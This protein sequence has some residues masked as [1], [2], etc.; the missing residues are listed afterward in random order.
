[1]RFALRLAR[2]L[3]RTLHELA[4]TMTAE[5]FALHYMDSCIEP[6]GDARLAHEMAA[7]RSATLKGPVQNAPCIADCLLQFKRPEPAEREEMDPLDFI[8]A[9]TNP[10]A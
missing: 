5:E 10:K 8:A 3:G 6:W 1:M 9:A 7:L 4:H 2:S